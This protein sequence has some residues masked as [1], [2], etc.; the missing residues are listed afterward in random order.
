MQEQWNSAN[1]RR[2]NFMINNN[3]IVLRRP[4]IE[5]ES[6]D[7]LSNAKPIEVTVFS[8]LETYAPWVGE[9]L[10]LEKN[11]EQICLRTYR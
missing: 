5:P 4:G 10:T 11:F 1:D 6:P 7:S 9:S 8:Y 3:E 2:K